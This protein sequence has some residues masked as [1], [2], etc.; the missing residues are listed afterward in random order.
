MYSLGRRYPLLSTNNK[1]RANICRALC[2]SI[3]A[4]CDSILRLARAR[5]PPSQ[6]PSPLV[7]ILLPTLNGAATLPGLLAAVKAQDCDGE[8]EIVAFD[9]GSSDD[10]LELLEQAGARVESIPEAEFSHGGTRN[11]IAAKAQGQFLVFLSQ[12]VHPQGTDFLTELLKPFSDERVAGVC[13]RVLPF[14]GSDP[15]TAR[16]VLD[17]PEASTVSCT[18]DLDSI[19]PVWSVGPTERLGYLRFNNVASSIRAD[20]FRT[21]PFPEVEFGED[22]AWAARVLTAGYRLAFTSDSVVTHGHRYTPRQAYRRYRVDAAF[23]RAAHG[24][25][26]RPSL[27]SVVRGV[28]FELLADVRYLNQHQWKGG[29][30]LLRAPALRMAQVWGQY[31]GCR[32]LRPLDPNAQIMPDPKAKERSEGTASP[33]S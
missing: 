5:P 15:L 21:Y 31:Q 2:E 23:H 27:F 28:A 22:F 9:S 11:Q 26:M 29:A 4:P 25:R 32:T 30:A 3:R 18:R 10:T 14:P 17:L 1:H 13:A 33:N 24:W 12:D 8:V 19:G 20:V 16:T 7:S 6:M